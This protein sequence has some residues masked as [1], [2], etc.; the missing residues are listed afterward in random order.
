[1]IM[2]R[3]VY[4]FIVE[5]LEELA[6]NPDVKHFHP[7]KSLEKVYFF[8]NREDHK[9]NGSEAAILD[10]NL[11]SENRDL[12][13]AE[14]PSLEDYTIHEAYPILHE[15]WN[16]P[17]HMNSG[18]L[19]DNLVRDDKIQTLGEK[20]GRVFGHVT[21]RPTLPDSVVSEIIYVLLKESPK[22]HTWDSLYP[23]VFS[24]L[25]SIHIMGKDLAHSDPHLCYIPL[26]G[27]KTAKKSI[28][29]NS[30]I[31]ISNKLKIDMPKLDSSGGGSL[32]KLGSSKWGRAIWQSYIRETTSKEL[33]DWIS[34]NYSDKWFIRATSNIQRDLK[35]KEGVI[36]GTGS[37]GLKRGLWQ[38]QEY[39]ANEEL[40]EL[41]ERRFF[42]LRES[43][44][45]VQGQ[46]TQQLHQLEYLLFDLKSLTSEIEYRINLMINDKN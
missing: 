16:H 45:S 34:Y 25:Q 9:I 21:A 35:K 1:M 13:H 5:Y 29:N 8:H 39:S 40:K 3:L 17:Y 33:M 7:V 26:N 41:I 46:N 2:D 30:G 12:R 15:Q 22:P 43:V 38:Y 14:P 4:N 44:R 19:K 31:E 10:S 6:K 42:Q 36:V 18:R 23:S 37:N 28:N 27:H 11:I 24:A 32:M 20:R